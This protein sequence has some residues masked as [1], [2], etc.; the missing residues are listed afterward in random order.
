MTNEHG[1]A[2]HSEHA[3]LK[4]LSDPDGHAR[5]TGSCGETMEFW[6]RIESGRLTRVVFDTDG[7]GSSLAAGMAAARLAEGQTTDAAM[8]IGPKAILD[9]LGGFPAESHHCL[10]LAAD[11]LR[12]AIDSWTRLDL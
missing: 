2:Q 8:L 10:T 12:A 11:A 6:L 7:C 4:A 5:V 9:F 3:L 1:P